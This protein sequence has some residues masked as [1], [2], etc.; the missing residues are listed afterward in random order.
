MVHELEKMRVN[1]LVTLTVTFML[2]I[3]FAELN[4]GEKSFTNIPRLFNGN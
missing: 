2:K 1:D 3:A 4:N